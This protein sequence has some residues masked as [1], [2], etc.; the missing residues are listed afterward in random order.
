MSEW[1]LNLTAQEVDTTAVGEK[2][3]DSVKSV[4]TGGGSIDFLVSRRKTL[5]QTGA[6]MA[7]STSLM[8]LLLLSEKG[9][10]ADAEF[11]MIDGQEDRD[12]LLPGDLFYQTQVLVTSIA[13]NTRATDIIAGSL[14]F[15]T[16][17]E[18]RLLMGTN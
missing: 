3:G 14:N 10:K 16:V 12:T 15:V 8:R 9:C 7:D 1:S 18:I 13:I 6:P 4:V 17:G 5:D 2:F 11:W